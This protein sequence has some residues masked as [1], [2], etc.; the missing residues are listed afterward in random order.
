M[1]VE[2]GDNGEGDDGSNCGS[3]FYVPYLKTML[4]AEVI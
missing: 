1:L 2:H 3:D 4:V